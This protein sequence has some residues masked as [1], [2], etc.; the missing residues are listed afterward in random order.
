[1]NKY[2]DNDNNIDKTDNID[3]VIDGNDDCIGDKNA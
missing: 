2:D 1:M 3:G